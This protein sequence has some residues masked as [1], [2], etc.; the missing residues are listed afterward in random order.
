MSVRYI[1]CFEIK[2]PLG[3]IALVEDKQV[4]GASAKFLNE[5]A[6]APFLMLGLTVHHSTDFSASII[7]I[8]FSF[9]CITSI[10]IVENRNVNIPAYT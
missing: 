10:T 4:V 1:F 9:T 7:S 3:I 2:K 5:F 8:R 6:D